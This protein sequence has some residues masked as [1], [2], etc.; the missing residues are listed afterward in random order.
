VERN[1]QYGWKEGREDDRKVGKGGGEGRR[2]GRKW[3]ER[4]E[5]CAEN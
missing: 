3:P 4:I 5:G 2:E 1:N